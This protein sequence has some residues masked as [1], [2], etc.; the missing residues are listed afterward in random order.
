MNG[1]SALKVVLVGVV[2]LLLVAGLAV[3]RLIDHRSP[4]VSADTGRSASGKV[5]LRLSGSNTIGSELAPVLA[6]AFLKD[7]GAPSTKI[8]ASANDEE[9]SVEGT[10]P[11]DSAPSVIQI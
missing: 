4:F 5:I 2:V 11:G 8:V 9:K 1:G 3:Y 6:Q 10:L 7:Q